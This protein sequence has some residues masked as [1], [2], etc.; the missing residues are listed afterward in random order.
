MPKRAI[1]Y[2]LHVVARSL[3]VKA[4]H[5]HAKGDGMQ[6]GKRGQRPMAQMESD[7]IQIAQMAGKRNEEKVSC[8]SDKR[9]V[10]MLRLPFDVQR[11]S[12]M[13]EALP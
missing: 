1:L 5:A 3:A 2:G 9:P 13:I 11:G 6:C 7:K 4:G 10:L 12:R 8:E